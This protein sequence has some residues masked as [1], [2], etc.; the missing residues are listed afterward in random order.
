[1]RGEERG[2]REEELAQL[3]DTV[4]KLK[5][6]NEKERIKSLELESLVRKRKHNVEKQRKL[7]ESQSSFRLCL[8]R[9]VRDTMHQ[10]ALCLSP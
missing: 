4:R 8:E 10:Y 9:V 5:L 6:E 2:K 1:M 3:E 7:A